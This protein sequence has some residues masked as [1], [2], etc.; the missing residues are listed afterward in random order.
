[1]KKSNFFA[2][3]A[4]GLFL[5][6]SCSQDEVLNEVAK[7]ATVSTRVTETSSTAIDYKVSLRLL[8]SYLDFAKKNVEVQS[9]IPLVREGDT[10][11]YAVQYSQG[12]DIIAADQRLTP[13][14]VTSAEG[15]IPQP[16]TA[17][18]EGLLEYIQKIRL[19][20]DSLKS[21]MWRILS[22]MPLKTRALTRGDEYSAGMWVKKDST[23][24]GETTLIDHLMSTKWGQGKPWNK[25]AP[26]KNYE[27]TLL[28]C[29]TVALGQMIKYF[30]EKGTITCSIPQTATIVEGASS[31]AAFLNESENWW[32]N[33]PDYW[34]EAD[35]TR[36]AAFL[37]KLGTQMGVSWG[38]SATSGTIYNIIAGLDSYDIAY[39]RQDSYNFNTL[40]AYVSSNTPVLICA[41][42]HAFV[43]DRY[44]LEHTKVYYTY[45]W[46][47]NHVATEW[48]KQHYS[49][50]MF[51]A[52]D[53]KE[54]S[55]TKIVEKTVM[56]DYYIG[57]NWGWNG[58][59]DNILYSAR[60]YVAPFI[61]EAGESP[62]MN[63]IYD[64]YW[65][66]SAGTFDTVKH[67]LYNFREK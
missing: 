26:R 36:V 62:G 58:I 55:T 11:A 47:P 1:M 41:N 37:A 54:G 4:L 14:M 8:Q 48:E 15:T 22:P 19:G 13:I 44:K 51:E 5:F 42:N 67:M 56:K 52:P 45:E 40:Y 39:T 60:H 57:M 2:T 31:T 66:T 29:T 28:G 64:P 63:A 34:Y 49:L 20:T 25:Y 12:W 16:L 23:Y 43:V 7:T 61:D 38:T 33:L 3:L 65:E 50:D 59:D 53:D 6:A 24:D 21:G 46:D 18:I 17:P 27:R 30:C 10:L 9:I 32:I 35:T